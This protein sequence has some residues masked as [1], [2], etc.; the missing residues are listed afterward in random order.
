MAF[1]RLEKTENQ[2]WCD[3]LALEAA[4][5]PPAFLHQ[6]IL[7]GSGTEQTPPIFDQ[8]LRANLCLRPEANLQLPRVS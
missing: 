2:R 3:R 6:V 5:P 7:I 4:C 8:D 1:L